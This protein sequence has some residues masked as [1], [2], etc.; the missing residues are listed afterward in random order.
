MCEI[1][2]IV[3]IYNK[4]YC[5]FNTVKCIQNQTFEDFELLLID[6]GSKDRSGKICDALSSRDA[7]I[8]TFHT[9]NRGVSAARNL[10]IR[11]A[12]GKYIGFI[13]ADDSVD[14]TFLEKLYSAIK[15]NNADLAVCDYY[16]TKNREKTVHT[17]QNH[18]SGNAMFEIIRQDL[19][20]I[21]WNKLYVR[22]KIKHL[23]DEN[24]TLCEDSIFCA[25]YCQDNLPKIAYVH[26]VL[27]G[28]S[29]RR[30]GLTSTYQKNSFDGISKMFS[31]NRILTEQISDVEL[32][33][34]AIHHVYRAYFYGVYTFIFE[35][36]SKGPMTK[37]T[38]ARIER[39][40]NN[41]RYRRVIRFVWKYALQDRRAEG[42]GITEY[43]LILFSL[44]KMKRGIYFV[45]KVRLYRTK[46]VL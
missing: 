4:E 33:Y 31:I 15:K 39:I 24:I 46:K 21:V 23:F 1:S 35:N 45:S 17:Y 5:I 32:K 2:I 14:K 9:P 36:L 43:L 7:R 44:L 19:Q 6:D 37:E 13:D 38:L 29:V 22:E 25:W 41:R 30:N 18:H 40:I 11:K 12:K 27:Y 8:K 16:Q 3:P 10:G 20:C 42:T 26:E 28:Y 34:L